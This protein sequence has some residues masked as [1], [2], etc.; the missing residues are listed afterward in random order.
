MGSPL[1]PADLVGV[2][3]CEGVVMGLALYSFTL[4]AVNAY[5]LSQV[6]N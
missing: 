2:M 6:T 1:E 4:P 5:T 3:V